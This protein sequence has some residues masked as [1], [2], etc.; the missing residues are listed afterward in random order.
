MLY[1]PRQRERVPARLPLLGVAWVVCV[2]GAAMAP[3]A[4]AESIPCEIGNRA[5]GLSYQ[6]TSREVDAREASMG[7]RLSRQHQASMDQTLEDLD[8]SLM[9][10]ERLSTASVPRFS[11]DQ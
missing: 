5:N 4:N 9:R 6:P 11:P 10:N 7:V 3:I 1:M 8:R 2:I